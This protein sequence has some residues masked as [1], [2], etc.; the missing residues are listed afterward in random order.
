MQSASHEQDDSLVTFD[1]PDECDPEPLPGEVADDGMD[2]DEPEDQNS[3]PVSPS[4][5]LTNPSEPESDPQIGMT[6]TLLH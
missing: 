3:R 6:F 5:L 1:L 4:R 2:F